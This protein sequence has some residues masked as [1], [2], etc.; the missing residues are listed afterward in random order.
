M[1]IRDQEKQELKKL[2]V[3][4]IGKMNKV[5]MFLCRDRDKAEDLVA[6][7]L[8]KVC[9]NIHRLRDKSKFK[10]WMFKIMNNTFIS[11]CREE[12]S[13]NLVPLDENII[14]IE[15]EISHRNSSTLNIWGPN[16]EQFLINKLLDEDIKHNINLL[17]EEFRMTIILCD[18]ENR[19]YKEISEITGVPVGT[20]RS[21]LS[22]GRAILQKNLHHLAEEMGIIKKRKANAK[23]EVCICK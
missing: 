20:V 12:K 18:I 7:T 19:S 13:R 11:H 21:R 3:P 15:K 9:E 6:E 22:R 5:A 17:P 14:K 23:E 16:P 10:S 4:I 2:I 8:L 1:S